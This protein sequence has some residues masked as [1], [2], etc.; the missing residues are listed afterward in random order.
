[1]PTAKSRSEIAVFGPIFSPLVAAAPL[2]ELG[3][4]NPDT[5][6]A[7]KLRGLS[8]VAAF[9]PHKIA[10]PAMADAFF[11]GLW[12]I[13]DHLDESH[14]ISQSIETPTGSYWHAIMHRREGDFSNSKYWF[15]RVGTHPVFQPL[16]ESAQEIFAERLPGPWDPFRFVD[17]CAAAV[18]TGSTAEEACRRAQQRE[19][20]LLL[21]FCY[22]QAIQ[23][24]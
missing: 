4:G 1:M 16:A 19:C 8:P 10:D 17:Q 7:E 6:T 11:A 22:R 24:S 18:R 14:T 9:A 3:P 23:L 13:Y 12:L 2:N 5:G 20:R 21:E 15:R